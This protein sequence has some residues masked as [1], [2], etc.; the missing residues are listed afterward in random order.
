ML[1]S[2]SRS[3]RVDN[4]FERSQI[5]HSRWTPR[6][7]EICTENGL[8]ESRTDKYRVPPEIS[9][10]FCQTQFGAY[11]E[12]SRGAM[13]NSSPDSKG[14]Q[15]RA[16]LERAHTELISGVWLDHKLEVTVAKKAD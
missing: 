4:H 14:P 12:I 1:A 7:A 2:E 3:L 10:P 6:L 8:L 13:D 9:I 15:F 11:A 5:D 16:L